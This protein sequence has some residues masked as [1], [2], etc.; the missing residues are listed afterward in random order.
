MEKASE[1]SKSTVEETL[2]SID[3][4]L[5]RLEE[6]LLDQSKTQKISIEVSERDANNLVKK[7]T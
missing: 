5:K 3:S 2:Q 4:T 1:I 6:I 7:H